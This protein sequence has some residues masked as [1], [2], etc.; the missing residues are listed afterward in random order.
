MI[1]FSNGQSIAIAN[2]KAQVAL[3]QIGKEGWMQLLTQLCEFYLTYLLQKSK[4]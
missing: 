1:T 2:H 3:T 4:L